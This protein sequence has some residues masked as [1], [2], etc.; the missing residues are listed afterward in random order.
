MLY[1]WWLVDGCLFPATSAVPPPPDAQLLGFSV[2]HSL[3]EGLFIAS[4]CEL[5]AEALR[6]GPSGP[7]VAPARNALLGVTLSRNRSP[8]PM[9]DAITA[10]RLKSFLEEQPLHKRFH[11]E[12]PTTFD[13][14]GAPAAI[15]L[16]C[17]R[18][19]GPQTF[20]VNPAGY[21]Q[22]H[23][24]TARYPTVSNTCATLTYNCAACG[25][26]RV[27][28]LEFGPQESKEVTVTQSE[29]IGPGP[30]RH[31]ETQTFV[32]WVQK[33][34]QYPRWEYTL[35]RDTT[36]LLGVG[37]A[38]PFSRGLA[39]EEES[40]GLGAC[41]YYRWIVER[42][43]ER[44]IAERSESLAGPEREDFDGAV[45]RAR[46]SRQMSEM[47]A[48]AKQQLPT[49]AQP[50][51]INPLGQ[52]YDRLSELIHRGTDQS[53]MEKVAVLRQVLL[54]LFRRLANRGEAR[55]YEEKL[56]QLAQ[57]PAP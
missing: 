36:K 41:G 18:C 23:T 2:A 11:L 22:Q 7:R 26:P 38:E 29:P 37:L 28:L 32:A 56:R 43:I 3:A 19:R 31:K 8:P 20:R 57:S 35:D 42:L 1:G 48:L 27:F 10:V 9:S 54:A 6:Y 40:F 5:Q 53:C 21:Q 34:G 15:N 24:A 44:L 39:C 47:I 45:A 49:D 17:R 4:F 50:R 25:W 14:L 33:V 55:D 13:N 12:L 46:E 30:V 52:I 51:D 16:P